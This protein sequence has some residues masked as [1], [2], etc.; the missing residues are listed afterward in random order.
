VTAASKR[1]ACAP[2]A[3]LRIPKFA[4]EV[5]IAQDV[6]DLPLD[7]TFINGYRIQDVV[8]C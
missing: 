7:A 6:L 5:K 8:K 4:N 2:K 1:S 3:V